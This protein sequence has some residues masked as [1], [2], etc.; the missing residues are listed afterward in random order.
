VAPLGFA[1]ELLLSIGVLELSAR[2]EAVDLAAEAGGFGQGLCLGVGRIFA[3]EG[4]GERHN[5]VPAR[6][7]G[8]QVGRF[9][10]SFRVVNAQTSHV[11]GEAALY[12]GAVGFS[13]GRS[14]EM[15]DRSEAVGD[16][17]IVDGGGAQHDPRWG[18]AEEVTRGGACTVAD[19]LELTLQ[20]VQVVGGVDKLPDD[21][22]GLKGIFHLG[23]DLIHRPVVLPDEGTDA[24]EP[25]DVAVLGLFVPWRAFDL[26]G[27]VEEGEGTLGSIIRRWRR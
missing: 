19:E 4:W 8:A 10:Q 27:F 15:E 25:L 18:G 1:K 16:N 13:R 6:G 26:G 5:L 17:V 3:R 12:E 14:V 9:G 24:F 20:A 22:E 21:A 23:S 2:V 11:E 7:D